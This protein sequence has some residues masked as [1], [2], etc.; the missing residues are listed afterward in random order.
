[1][2]QADLGTLMCACYSI[3]STYVYKCRKVLCYG[4]EQGL[5]ATY[6]LSIT[7]AHTHM[8]GTSLLTLKNITPHP[9]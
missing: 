9:L 4:L 7:H 3:A 5:E 8:V 6:R 2:M 1:M